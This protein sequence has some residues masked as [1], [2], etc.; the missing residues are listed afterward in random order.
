PADGFGIRLADKLVFS[1]VRNT[2]GGRIRFFVS[3]GAPLSAEIAEFFH[4]A[5]I[6]VLEGYG[7]TE[8]TAASH[9]NRPDDY[10]FGTVGPAIPGVEVKIADD[11]EILIRG[12][13]VMKCYYNKPEETAEAID[14]DGWFHTG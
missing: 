8:V 11:G 1:K 9:V 2:F 14:G 5:G 10:V 7:L 6:L 3:G 4:A 12:D 13:N